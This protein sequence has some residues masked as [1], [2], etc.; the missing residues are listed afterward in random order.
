MS[1]VDLCEAKPE[2]TSERVE[3]VCP[4]SFEI[5]DAV[6]VKMGFN[7]DRLGKLNAEQLVDLDIYDR[8]TV[9]GR[10]AKTLETFGRLPELDIRPGVTVI[11]GENGSGKTMLADIIV[12]ALKIEL[13]RAA[14]GLSADDD[15]LTCMPIGQNFTPLLSGRV[16]NVGDGAG[17]SHAAVIARIAQAM[18]VRYAVLHGFEKVGDATRTP[19]ALGNIAM[20]M[21]SR[22]AVDYLDMMTLDN[23]RRSRYAHS[24]AIY[25]EPELGMSPRRHMGLL[26]EIQQRVDRGSIE[27][28]PSNSL[29]LFAASVPR[30]DLEQPERGVFIPDAVA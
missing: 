23:R 21:S 14:N 26:G 8:D 7:R 12:Q 22:Q 2:C 18:D 16:M 17:A 5:G 24:I 30:I 11:F 3:A 19:V 10:L 15:V 9:V 29:I 28:V 25:D 1:K 6:H 13:F 4:P 20:G 27:L